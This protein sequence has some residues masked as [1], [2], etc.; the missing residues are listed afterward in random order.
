MRFSK[1]A[2]SVAVVGVLVALSFYA[3]VRVSLH[4]VQRLMTQ[5]REI[6]VGTFDPNDRADV[7]MVGDSITQLGQWGEY[8]PCLTIANRGAVGDGAQEALKRI[9]NIRSTR[10]RMA[11]IM[12]GVN[13]L[14]ANRSVR[15]AAQNE[16]ELAAD[17]QKD[18]ESPVILSTLYVSKAQKDHQRINVGVDELNS[19]L[20]LWSESNN[21]TFLNLIPLM[22]EGGA[23]HPDMAASDGMHL[24]SAG[25]IAVRAE[26]KPL[27]EQL[28]SQKASGN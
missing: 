23:L 27:I 12:F 14:A 10:A 24:N 13:D 19:D 21:V 4:R 16:E 17:L 7:V 2:V 20:K 28:C 5:M 8:F 15:N 6:T 18:G 3:G 1:T 22:S 9:D 26:L 25:Y 11:F